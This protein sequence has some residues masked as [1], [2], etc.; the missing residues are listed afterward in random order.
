MSRTQT[1][2]IRDRLNRNKGTPCSYEHVSKRHTKAMLTSIR[3]HK[4][5]RPGRK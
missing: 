3:K 1:K 4:V 2:K 5:I